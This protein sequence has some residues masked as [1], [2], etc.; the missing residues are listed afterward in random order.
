MTDTSTK[1]ICLWSGP[2]NISTALMYSFAQRPDT[3]VYDEPLYGYY[4]KTTNAKEYHPGAAEVVADMECDGQKVVEMM[5][6]THEKP[7]LIFL[8]VPGLPVCVPAALL[9]KL[10]GVPVS[11]CAVKIASINFLALTTFLARPSFSYLSY[12]S[13]RN[14]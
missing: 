1:R 8:T 11:I 7:D 10:Y 9:S 12:N 4:L 13:S 2:R 14:A 3:R 5:M 6:A